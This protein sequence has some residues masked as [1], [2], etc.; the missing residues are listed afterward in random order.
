MKKK[1]TRYAVFRLFGSTLDPGEVTAKFHREPLLAYKPN[2]RQ[3]RTGRPRPYGMWQISSEH[4]VASGEL[5]VHIAW[6]LD[7]LEP[8]SD[9]LKELTST[10]GIHADL[11]CFWEQESN[12]G[13]SFS[14]PLVGRIAK[15]E[16]ELGIE[17]I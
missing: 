16:L 2:E 14:A 6:I 9:T 12:E 13:L 1:P 7:Q 3:D 4:E 8:V 15:L 17:V 5:D 11:F 10:E